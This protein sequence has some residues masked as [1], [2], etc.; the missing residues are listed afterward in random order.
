VHLYDYQA[1]S[2]KTDLASWKPDPIDTYGKLG[3]YQMFFDNL[4]I[5]ARLGNK[6]AQDILTRQSIAW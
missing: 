2:D 4:K 5:S 6:R 1:S 3:D